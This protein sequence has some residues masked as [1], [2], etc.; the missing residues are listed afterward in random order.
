MQN[1][2]GAKP[3]ANHAISILVNIAIDIWWAVSSG[4]D[5]IFWLFVTVTIIQIVHAVVV[6]RKSI[7][8]EDNGVMINGERISYIDIADVTAK[9]RR[10]TV[11][12]SAGKR[13]RLSINNAQDVSNAILA[14]KAAISAVV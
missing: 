4:F 9:R 8:V 10:I 3:V 14:N 11:K 5:L 6:L 1:I 13:Y 12:T 7:S 2:T